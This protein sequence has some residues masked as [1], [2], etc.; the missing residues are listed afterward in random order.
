LTTFSDAGKG[1]AGG[2]V[3]IAGCAGPDCTGF[4]GPSV[5]AGVDAL[6]DVGVD[7]FKDL[8]ACKGPG[9]SGFGE[10]EAVFALAGKETGGRLG[11]FG[12]L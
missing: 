8:D 10:W 3:A 2:G 1:V 11:G 9:S 12:W 5:D 6:V 4:S 7:V